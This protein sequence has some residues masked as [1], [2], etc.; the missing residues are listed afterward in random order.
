MI[1][2]LE[3]KELQKFQE[4]SVYGPSGEK[5]KKEQTIFIKNNA[6]IQN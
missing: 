1:K 3:E 6:L 2:Q 4:Q 5:N